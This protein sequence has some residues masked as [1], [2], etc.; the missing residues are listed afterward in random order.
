[1]CLKPILLA[2]A[3]LPALR[4]KHIYEL[5]TIQIPHLYSTMTNRQVWNHHQLQRKEEGN[6]SVRVIVGW[7]D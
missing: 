1:M 6:V 2:D 4:G 5:L 7:R 3:D